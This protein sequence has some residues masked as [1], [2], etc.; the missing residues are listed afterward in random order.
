MSPSSKVPAAFIFLVLLRSAM[1]FVCAAAQ[2]LIRRSTAGL[3][4][5]QRFS[6][7]LSAAVRLAGLLLL[8]HLI[9]LSGQVRRVDI[10]IRQVDRHTVLGLAVGLRQAD[11]SIRIADVEIRN[12]DVSSRAASSSRPG[13]WQQTTARITK[14]F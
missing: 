5:A 4:K 3:L 13:R 10:A 7:A 9:A 12:A 8:R 1:M 11:M 2:K 14:H 6:G